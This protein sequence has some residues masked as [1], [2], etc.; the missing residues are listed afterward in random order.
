M[1]KDNHLPGGFLDPEIVASKF[2]LKLGQEIADFGAGS[3]YF[4]I[5][6]AKIVGD[7]GKVNAI[8]ILD[9]SLET[10]RSKANLE[11]LKNIK[12]IKGNLEVIGGSGLDDSS[13]DFVLLANILFQNEDKVEIIR[14]SKRV[15]KDDG[16]MVIIDWEKGSG[17]FGPP[18]EYRSPKETIMS[19]AAQE[20]FIFEKY[21]DVDK[22]H[23][24]MI[25]R[26][27]K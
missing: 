26:I 17:G 7:S 21:I 19:L 13:Q 27:K 14:E 12:T 3:G 9:S 18:D 8:D 4:T 15:L 20:G 10:I 16:R 23:F 24:G 22:F 1:N 25:F 6:M 5:I 11:G 2:G